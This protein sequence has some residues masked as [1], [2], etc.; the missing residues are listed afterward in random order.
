VASQ[1]GR[2]GAGGRDFQDVRKGACGKSI[3]KIP[4]ENEPGKK[5]G[6]T[7]KRGQ[8]RDGKRGV[9]LGSEAVQAGSKGEKGNPKV[10]LQK[11]GS[12]QGKNRE[13]QQQNKARG[14]EKEG[15]IWKKKS[16]GEPGE[17]KGWWIRSLG[18]PRGV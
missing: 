16:W 7:K 9:F 11:Y 2:G 3:K 10:W 5:G 4:T 18:V 8:W 6:L 1:G 13:K 12:A 15:K 14:G 17:L